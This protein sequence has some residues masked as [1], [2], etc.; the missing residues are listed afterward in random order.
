M[1]IF[2]SRVSKTISAV[3]VLSAVCFELLGGRIIR[4]AI[5]ISTPFDRYIILITN[6]LLECSDVLSYHLRMY[7]LMLYAWCRRALPAGRLPRTPQPS[8]D[9]WR[10]IGW[11]SSS[12]PMTTRWLTRPASDPSPHTSGTRSAVELSL[13]AY[14]TLCGEL[15]PPL[16]YCRPEDFHLYAL[17]DVSKH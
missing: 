10:R 7:L 6:I 9:D 4:L 13:V 17:I 3:G 1:I 15:N 11:A 2:R 8:P 14:P 12:L 16:H 5:S